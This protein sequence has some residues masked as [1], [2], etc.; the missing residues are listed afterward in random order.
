MRQPKGFE[1]SGEEDKVIHLKRAIYGLR[2]SGRKWYEDLMST[3][4]KFGFKQ[5]RVE[6][7]VFYRFDQDTT[8]LAVDINNITITGN[9]HRTMQRFKD[10][11]SSCYG[12]KDTGNLCWLLGIG[13]NRDHKN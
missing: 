13:I 10:K 11:L 6:H 4:I 1:A 7:T 5:C 12:I 8:I 2:Q 3:L 9:S